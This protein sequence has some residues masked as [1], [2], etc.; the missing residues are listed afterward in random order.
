[1]GVEIR[2]VKTKQDLRTFINL[3]AKIHKNHS[4]WVPPIYM[5][6]WVF[7]NSKKNKSFSYSDT[8]LLLAYKEGRIAGRIMGIIN[9]RYN[10]I[11]NE[12]DGRFCFM[13][14]WDDQEV[15]NALISYVENWAKE[16]GMINLVGP[17]GFSDK[18]PQGFL[19]E[20]FNEPMV[21]AANCN[22]PYMPQLLE[23]KGYE[24]KVDC[25]VY[26]IM[27]PERVP[28]LYYK[29]Y[30]R[31]MSRKNVQVLEFTKRSQLK[32]LIKPILTL[33]NETF[34]DIYAFAPFEDYEMADFANRYLM[35]L[36]PQ[37]IKVVTNNQGE[38]IGFFIA[39]PDISEGIIASK[40]KMIPFGIFQIFS[41]QKKTKQLDLLLGG[42]KK[43]Y[44]GTGIDVAMG[45]KMFET[46]IKRGMEYI[47]THLEL[48]DNV[49]MNAEF[50]FLGKEIYKR[51][52]I[53]T[54]GI[55]SIT[56]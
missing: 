41:A 3:P 13:E 32:P 8:I 37:F 55:N 42:V 14:T 49:K 47:D 26:K 56:N 44:Q 43:E 24:K 50:K 12:K 54:K 1:M 34:K 31:V 11:H 28:E 19:V 38:V 15:F 18:D 52:R 7:F 40:G 27:I 10:E 48:E 4:N 25:V 17:L 51:Y 33:L 16:K 2:E 21:I 36:D 23:Q 9:H 53:F 46:A 20:G 29:I 39:M 30:D 6:D 45:I 35:I 5:D 22:F